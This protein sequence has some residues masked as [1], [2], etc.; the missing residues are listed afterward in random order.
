MTSKNLYFNLLREDIKRRAWV[1]ALEALAMFFAL[2]IATALM[3]GDDSWHDEERWQMLANM[4]RM[5]AEWLSAGNGLIIFLVFVFAILCSFSGFSYLN[6]RKKVDFYHS[7]PVK[8]GTLFSVYYVNGILMFVSV[9]LVNLLIALGIAAV[10]GA[11]MAKVMPAAWIGFGVHVVGFFIVYAT[12]TVAVLLTGNI[13]IGFLGSAV[14]FAYCPAVALIVRGF[15]QLWFRTY[16]YFQPYTGTDWFNLIMN[17]CSPV[18]AYMNMVSAVKW[19]EGG[20]AGKMIGTVAA[21]VVLTVISLVIHRLRPSESCG[22]AMAFRKSKPVIRILLVIPMAL[23]GSMIFWNFRDSFG[24]AVFGTL[25]IG[26]IAHCIIEIIYH[27]DFRK[28]FAHAAQMGICLAVSLLILCTFKFDLLGYDTYK[29]AASSVQSVAVEIGRIDEW[30]TYGQVQTIGCEETETL[31]YRWS[32]DRSDAFVYPHM[33]VTELDEVMR[34]VDAGI[35]RN[36]R[37]K[38][39][40]E[41]ENREE[42]GTYYAS[43]NVL[44]QLK[45]GRR[46]GRSYYM[47]LGMEREALEGLYKKPEYKKGVFPLLSQLPEE[48]AGAYYQEQNNIIQLEIGKEYGKEA[49]LAELLKA[50]QEELTG[51]TIETRSQESPI[52]MIQFMDQDQYEAVSYLKSHRRG[53]GYDLE[54]RCYYPV[55]PSFTKTIGLMKKYGV[56]PGTEVT[57]DQVDK[58]VITDS[59]WRYQRQTDGTYTTGMED[60]YD[61]YEVELPEERVYTFTEQDQIEAIMTALIPEDYAD[62]NAFNPT[63]YYSNVTVTVG[64]GPKRKEYNYRLDVDRVPEFLKQAMDFDAARKGVKYDW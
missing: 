45:S 58:L 29:P 35:A 30:V 2:P 47:P 16:G 7:L 53:S 5:I 4:T 11:D 10:N 19:E 55:Y 3:T 13:V 39:G 32:Y 9:Y 37:I 38:K 41:N 17:R 56:T 25:C 20:L 64:N 31:N 27:F 24:W 40:D 49:E 44:Y 43:V 26:A 33:Q 8:R 21:A 57:A 36:N 61:Y 34:L 62:M 63:D 1:I 28:L 6:S 12:V 51:L 54:Q 18:D 59:S 48:T 42:E 52:G 22:K 15:F 14:F 60:D 46:V 23:S 50:Y